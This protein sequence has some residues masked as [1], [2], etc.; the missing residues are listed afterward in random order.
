MGQER[1]PTLL[2]ALDS[3]LAHLNQAFLQNQRDASSKVSYAEIES[4]IQTFAHLN[5]VI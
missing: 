4:W 5:R 2:L 1:V 3:P